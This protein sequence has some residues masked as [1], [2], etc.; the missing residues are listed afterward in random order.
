LFAALV[1]ADD[2]Q[3]HADRPVAPLAR[4][5]R[6]VLPP[7][8]WR[9]RIS[10]TATPGPARKAPDAQVGVDREFSPA[11]TFGLWGELARN[12]GRD[13]ACRREADAGR[14]HDTMNKPKLNPMTG[15]FKIGDVV[16]L[17]SDG[18]T[19]TVEAI[20]QDKK[21]AQLMI[22]CRWFHGLE[23]QRK[24]KEEGFPPDALERLGGRS[25]PAFAGPAQAS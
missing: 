20:Y 18:P 1:G 2:P 14:L 15:E 17:T 23:G 11:A 16:R 4:L 13:R 7:L 24:L 19:M 8:I 9:T 6:A 21:T 12:R 3:T 22:W 25:P 5:R 10:A